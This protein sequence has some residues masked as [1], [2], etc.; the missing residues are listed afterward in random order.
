MTM[1]IY[2]P[3]PNYR[4]YKAYVAADENF[5]KKLAKLKRKLDVNHP[6]FDQLPELMTMI[7]EYKVEYITD[8]QT[9]V[10]NLIDEYE[11][12]IAELKLQLG[13]IYIG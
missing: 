12:K 9:A 7:E 4:N 1:G 5:F 10:K 2:D 13:N 3:E 11:K 8:K 6:L